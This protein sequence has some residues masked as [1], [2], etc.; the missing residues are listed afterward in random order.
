MKTKGNFYRRKTE[1]KPGSYFSENDKKLEANTDIKYQCPIKCHGEGVYDT[2]G[3]CPD[4]K[5]QMIP[6]NAGHIFY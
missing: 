4:S 6:V 2:P 1:E 5:M 3:M